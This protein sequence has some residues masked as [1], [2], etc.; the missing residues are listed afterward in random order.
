MTI[1]QWLQ[2]YPRRLS[3]RLLGFRAGR[4]LQ[5]SAEVQPGATA[6]LDRV[7]LFFPVL[8]S[9]LFLPPL[10]TLRSR[11][12]L[13]LGLGLRL[14]HTQDSFRAE[15]LPGSGSNLYRAYDSEGALYGRMLANV[16]RK[17]LENIWTSIRK[18]PLTAAIG[19]FCRDVS[20]LACDNTNRLVSA[21]V[22]S[23]VPQ[24][25]CFQTQKRYVLLFHRFW[26]IGPEE[27]DKGE[28]AEPT[29]GKFSHPCSVCGTPRT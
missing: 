27:L 24:R 10:P 22:S 5:K 1:E 19:L 18:T 13:G 3:H 17:Y 28:W 9:V 11:L 15:N 8:L 4:S 14:S 26:S 25:H 29:R 21:S 23:S 12:R 16:K 6:A 2:D 20:S 7:W